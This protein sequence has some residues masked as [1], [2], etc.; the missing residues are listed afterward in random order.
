MITYPYPNFGGDF[1][2]T[3]LKL[4]HWYVIT[5][6]YSRILC[7]YDNS[8]KDLFY[9][10]VI[11][12][13]AH[14]CIIREWVYVYAIIDQCLSWIKVIYWLSFKGIHHDKLME[15]LLCEFSSKGRTKRENYERPRFTWRLQVVLPFSQLCLA[16]LILVKC[17]HAHPNVRIAHKK[18][19]WNNECKFWT[20]LNAALYKNT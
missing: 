12:H 16:T 10:T 9:I 14:V 18:Q 7:W 1:A 20:L 4:W 6:F 5:A 11:T 15:L 8:E 17:V 3:L 2:N 19:T 13:A